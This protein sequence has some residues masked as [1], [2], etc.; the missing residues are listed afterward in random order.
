VEFEC[1]WFKSQVQKSGGGSYQTLIDAVLR[2]LVASTEGHLEDMV[3][4]VVRDELARYRIRTPTKRAR[5]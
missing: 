5:R 2:G 3:R 4:R 1:E